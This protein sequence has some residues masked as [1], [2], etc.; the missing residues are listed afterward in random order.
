MRI[1]D[2]SSDVCSSDLIAHAGVEELRRTRAD[3]AGDLEAA[4]RRGLQVHVRVAVE[5]ADA[6]DA[7]LIDPPVDGAGV[8]AL[9]PVGDDDRLRV[10]AR[11]TQEQIR[12][13]ERRVGKGCVSTC[14]S[15]WETD[16]SK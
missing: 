11:R 10:D 6:F 3:V 14:R 13:A 5:Q 2:C 1:S 12:S 9:V 8:E 7:V 16:T 4:A 15:R